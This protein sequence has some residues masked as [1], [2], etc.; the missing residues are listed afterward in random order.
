MAPNQSYTDDSMV[1]TADRST[2][3]NLLTLGIKDH[4]EF[5]KK[6]VKYN[7]IQDESGQSKVEAHFSDGSVFVGDLLVGADGVNSLVRKQ[8]TPDSKQFDTNG[9]CIYGKTPLTNKLLEQLPASCMEWIT[10]IIDDKNLTLFMEP[11]KFK[12][13]K[14][15]DPNFIPETNDYIYWVLLGLSHCF[16]K[17]DQELYSLSQKELKEHQLKLIEKWNPQLK[18]IITSSDETKSSYISVASSFPDVYEWETNSN[19]TLMGDA[20]H[21]MSPTGGSGAN[22]A[23]YDCL[24]LLNAIKKGSRKQDL[25]QYEKEMREFSKKMILGSLNG[26]KRL[27]GFTS[28]EDCKVIEN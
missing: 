3:R 27:F 23:I 19:I 21:N 28:I 7:I 16:E 2:L 4:L 26:A 17:S 9:R 12:P 15:E 18:N 22:T 8:F 10:T 6:F 5:G 13:T 1:F 14:I 20:I 25:E 11:I 24:I